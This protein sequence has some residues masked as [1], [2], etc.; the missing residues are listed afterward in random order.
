VPAPN[1][2]GGRIPQEK[3]EMKN[4]E[5]RYK[6][7]CWPGHRLVPVSGSAW[8]D[9]DEDTLIGMEAAAGTEAVVGE[10]PS[11]ENPLR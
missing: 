11:G 7:P 4:P 10:N 9:E 6:P 5:N 2:P 3:R 1:G 8:Y